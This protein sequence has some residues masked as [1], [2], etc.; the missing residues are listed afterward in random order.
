MAE[1]DWL[2]QMD[3]DARNEWLDY[4]TGGFDIESR[5]EN[6]YEALKERGLFGED[7]YVEFESNADG[8]INGAVLAYNLQADS[9]NLTIPLWGAEIQACFDESGQV[10]QVYAVQALIESKAAILRPYI[11]A[12][13]VAV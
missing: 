7:W 13:E 2:D 5:L 6:V 3:E 4:N 8:D 10:Q 9:V 1:Q 11:E 12:A